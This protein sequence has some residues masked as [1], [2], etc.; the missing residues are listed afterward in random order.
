[1]VLI[2]LDLGKDEDRIVEVANATWGLKDKRK[3]LNR[4]VRE[5]NVYQENE[6]K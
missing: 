6:L 4:I 3:A 1:M 2:Q 5:W